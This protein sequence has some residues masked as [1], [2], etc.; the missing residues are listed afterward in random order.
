MHGPCSTFCVALVQLNLSCTQ[1]QGYPWYT[2][3]CAM[4]GGTSRTTSHL[5]T[6]S[7][8]STRCQTRYAWLFCTRHARVCQDSSDRQHWP[9]ATHGCD[10]AE[11]PAHAA[12]QAQDAAHGTLQVVLYLSKKCANPKVIYLVSRSRPH[13]KV[14]ELVERDMPVGEVKALL[15]SRGLAATF[16]QGASIYCK[17]QDG[18]TVPLKI[19]ANQSIMNLESKIAQQEVSGCA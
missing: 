16:V 5:L 12:A 15:E 17:R 13:Q 11:A 8:T 2:K 10:A 14:T 18:S 4:R 6:T 1:L 9:K 19:D 3:F 7:W